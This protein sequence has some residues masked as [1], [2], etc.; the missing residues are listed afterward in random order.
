MAAKMYF[1]EKV[2]VMSILP[3]CLIYYWILAGIFLLFDWN[4]F[5]KFKDKHKIQPQAKVDGGKLFKAA[6]LV[7]FNQLI[8]TVPATYVGVCLLEKLDFFSDVKASSIPSFPRLMTDLIGCAV[9][10]E[11][12]FFYNHRLLHHKLLYKHIHKI[13][14]E[15]TAPNALMSVYCHPIEHLLCNL[16]PTSAGFVILRTNL[17]TAYVFQLYAVTT[18]ML[19]HCGYYLPFLQIVKPEYH[20]YHHEK[21]VECFGNRILDTLHG[22]NKNF[23][24]IEE[25]KKKLLQA[26]L[27]IPRNLK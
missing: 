12:V 24:K 20:D 7:L 11:L 8:V 13:H 15:W 27:R 14:H 18:T 6:K 23:V 3:V 22:T 4:F 9:I 26:L 2:I 25:E 17:S 19:D 10:Y 1:N 5:P 21:F 16:L